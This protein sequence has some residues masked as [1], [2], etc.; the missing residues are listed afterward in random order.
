M[1]LSEKIKNTGLFPERVKE[2]LLDCYRNGRLEQGIIDELATMFE[3][4]ES[5]MAKIESQKREALAKLEN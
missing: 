5:A 2:F 1:D 4:E 3:E